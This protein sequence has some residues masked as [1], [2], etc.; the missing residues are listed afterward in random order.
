[1]DIASVV[2]KRRRWIIKFLW[3]PAFRAERLRVVEVEWRVIRGKLVHTD[4]GLDL[5]VKL[6]TRVIATMAYLGGY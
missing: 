2:M 6:L 5:L 3:Q 4:A 1:M